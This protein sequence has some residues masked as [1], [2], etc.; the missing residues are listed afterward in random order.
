MNARIIAKRV[1]KRSAGRRTWRV[2]KWILPGALLVWRQRQSMR[3][4][5]IIGETKE[6][7][8]CEPIQAR[9]FS[10][11]RRVSPV[12]EIH[13]QEIEA[14]RQR[15]ADRQ[16]AIFELIDFLVRGSD[17]PAVI[18]RKVMETA[19]ALDCPSLRIQKRT[20]LAA[21]CRVSKQRICAGV[22]RAAAEIL[23][24]KGQMQCPVDSAGGEKNQWHD[25]RHAI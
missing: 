8:L 11:Q 19:F 18:G 17:D 22:D 21:R 14:R 2:T 12:N 7:F 5:V 4:D 9:C 16:R 20:Q 13:M 10:H 1:G 3:A 6:N 25:G 24:I 23:K 15:S